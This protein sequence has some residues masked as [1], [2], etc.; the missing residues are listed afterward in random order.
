[1]FRFITNWFN[2]ISSKRSTHRATLKQQQLTDNKQEVKKRYIQINSIFLRT[3]VS[4]LV[5][6]FSRE[7]FFFG[8]HLKIISHLCLNIHTRLNASHFILY[9]YFFLLWRILILKVD[10]LNKRLIR[11]LNQI[12]SHNGWLFLWLLPR[13]NPNDD[14][15]TKKNT[16]TMIHWKMLLIK[17]FMLSGQ[18]NGMNEHNPRQWNEQRQIS[19]QVH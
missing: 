4:F 7:L 6:L 9:I 13:I 11:S 16:G 1:M 15:S 10:N 2:K 3:I 14:T 19:L 5:R 18:M 17:C 12:R 8:H